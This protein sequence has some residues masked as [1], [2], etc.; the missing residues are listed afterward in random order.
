[1]TGRLLTAEEHFRQDD[2]DW[3]RETVVQ[4]I[5]SV[6]DLFHW[7]VGVTR[8]RANTV[9]PEDDR[10]MLFEY[11]KHR[12]AH[13]V[14]GAYAVAA[15]GLPRYTKDISIGLRQG[16]DYAVRFWEALAEFGAPVDQHT[17]E[18]LPDDSLIHQIR[19]EPLRVGIR[20]NRPDTDFDRCRMRRYEAE[21]DQ[22][23]FAFAGY[24]ELI[25]IKRRAVR[26]QDLVDIDRLKQQKRNLRH[27]GD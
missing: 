9:L 11:S 16:K 26:G 13:M 12:V 18:E 21:F 24:E 27:A 5:E 8:P 4:R 25:E 17:I 23:I 7:I 20:K 15:H 3:A 14:V 2:D 1:M 6:G 10:D 22:L 19:T